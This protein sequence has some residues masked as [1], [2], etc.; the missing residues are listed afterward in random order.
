MPTTTIVRLL[1]ENCP[2]CSSK[3]EECY[4]IWQE[5]PDYPTGDKRIDLKR[6]TR[7]C[8]YAFVTKD[9]LQVW[10]KTPYVRSSSRKSESVAQ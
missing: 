1:N 8:G 6:C 2:R 5:E 7:N 10:K 4:E 3:L 9:E